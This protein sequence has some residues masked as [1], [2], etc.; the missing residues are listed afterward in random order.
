MEDVA[1]RAGVSRALVSLVFRNEPGASDET[2]LKVRA[3][4]AEI[5]YQLDTRARLLGSRQT[6]L[7]GVTFR[8][9][10]EFHAELLSQLYPAAESSGYELAL[11]GVTAGRS[12]HRAAQDLLA[13]RCD[14]LILLGPTIKATHLR[15]L[16][17][18]VP[19]VVVARPVAHDDID[20]VRT[21]DEQGA[22]LATRHLL[23]LG[24]T[25][26][27][28][29]DGGRAPG[30]AE[31]R[32]GYKATMREA[33][34]GD[35]TTVIPGGLEDA[36]GVAAVSRVRTD[37]PDCTAVTVF[38][39]QSAIGFLNSARLHGVRVPEQLSVVGYDNSKLSR[40]AWAEL[41]TVA[42]DTSLLAHAAVAICV[43]RIDGEAAGQRQLVAPSLFVG[44]T[45]GSPPS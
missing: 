8:V 34:L 38:N 26:I 12:E 3:A 18:Q 35:L 9:G 36:D 23:E 16:G 33:G 20:V 5:G 6:Q 15:E 11:S 14:A 2:R 29:V 4:A 30:A 19:A 43:G 31:R 40:S 39:D 44:S 21:D 7:I 13:L 25:R 10:H 22:A 17:R 41:T 32:R 45:T 28:H 24:H 37:Q 27:A 1:A 42:Q